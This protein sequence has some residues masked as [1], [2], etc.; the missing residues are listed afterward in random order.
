MTTLDFRNIQL[1]ETGAKTLKERLAVKK[2]LSTQQEMSDWIRGELSGT[3]LFDTPWGDLQSSY[4]LA[5]WVDV[6]LCHEVAVLIDL[7]KELLIGVKDFDCDSVHADLYWRKNE[8]DNWPRQALPGRYGWLSDADSIRSLLKSYRDTGTAYHFLDQMGFNQQNNEDGVPYKRFYFMFYTP[9]L[10]LGLVDTPIDEDVKSSNVEAQGVEGQPVEF[11]VPTWDK[12]LPCC[13][14]FFLKPERVP[15]GDRD[16]VLGSCTATAT[17]WLAAIDYFE[18]VIL[19]LE[20]LKEEGE[21]PAQNEKEGEEGAG[22]STNT[23]VRTSKRVDD[24]TIQRVL[25]YARSNKKEWRNPHKNTVPDPVFEPFHAVRYLL[26]A[27]FGANELFSG[28]GFTYDRNL[29]RGQREYWASSFR[30][31]NYRRVLVTEQ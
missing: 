8:A 24:K 26:D 13:R 30:N 9:M 15:Q 27:Q 12:V 5:F 28:D 29:K 20:S 4:L 1:T 16:W 18:K 3:L 11:F 17:Q 19:G 7:R 2:R 6:T 25:A 23:Q 14:D 10:L 22:S 21:T 31:M